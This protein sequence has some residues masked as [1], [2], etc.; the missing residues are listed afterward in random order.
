MPTIIIS[1]PIRKPS[2]RSVGIG[3]MVRH[4]RTTIA[5]IGRTERA[6]SAIFSRISVR[7][8]VRYED[9]IRH[10]PFAKNIYY[11]CSMTG[12]NDK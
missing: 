9:L 3:A 6:D 1:V 8:L 10:H 11:Y 4:S 7:F 2:I 12:K 5:T